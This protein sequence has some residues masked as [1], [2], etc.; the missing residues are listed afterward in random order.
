MPRTPRPGPQTID[1]PPAESNATPQAV[2]SSRAFTEIR[3]DIS[4]E[5]NPPKR[6]M[7]A[8]L[9]LSAE[10]EQLV[11]EHVPVVRFIARQIH[12]R[13]PQH[14]PI[15]DLYGA[16]VVG[17][18][19]ALD[20]FNPSKQVEFRS[21]A[22][23]RIRGSIL[24]SLRELDWGSR[25]MRRKARDIERTIEMLTARLNRPP[26]DR[27]IAQ[28]MN[29]HLAAYQKLQSKLK[30]LEIALLDP[31]DL[32]GVPSRHEDDPLFRFL[33]AELRER[34]AEAI[35][36]LGEQERR[37]LTLYYY[38]DLKQKEIASILGLGES[39]ISQI[40]NSAVIHL[41]SQLAGLAT[42]P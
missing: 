8:D 35:R 1:V 34:L 29:T 36:N 17:L 18:L 23:F 26:S 38:E 37:V 5:A 19:E 12:K 39:R 41:R 4:S 33:N 3:H 32:I 10:H 15:E 6:K 31:A 42:P 14:V 21:Y 2:L 7:N 20:R 27:E 13:L 22:Q 40:L 25:G 9:A 30:G 28:E 24:D 16:G 11:I